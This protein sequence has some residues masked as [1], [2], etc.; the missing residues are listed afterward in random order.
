MKKNEPID[1]EFWKKILA[2]F[3]GELNVS[4]A[5]FQDFWNNLSGEGKAGVL[6]FYGQLEK[7]EKA[8]SE[9][10]QEFTEYL[11]SKSPC[12]KITQ[13]CPNIILVQVVQLLI[14][15]NEGSQLNHKFVDV[16]VGILE[17]YREARETKDIDQFW[18]KNFSRKD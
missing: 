2:E 12:E 5:Q 16:V 17:Y 7:Y 15:S 6:S 10:A 8:D 1:P 4:A 18:R 11:R 3:L 13:I 14:K 9:N